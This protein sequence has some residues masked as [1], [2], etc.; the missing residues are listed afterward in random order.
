[1]SLFDGSA[2]F[3]Q[4][5]ILDT[6]TMTRSSN[7]ELPDGD[8]VIAH[9]KWFNIPKGF[10]FVVP[11]GTAIDAFLHITT[12]QRAGIKAIGE[13][14]VLICT[15]EKGPKGAQVRE[16][17]EILN[18]GMKPERVKQA[19]H[20]MAVRNGAENG[21]AEDIAPESPSL[22]L[23]GAVK[24]YKPDKGFGF[25]T[26]DDGQKDIFLHKSCLEKYG[27]D[28]LQ[29]GLRLS[30]QVRIVPKGREVL[31]FEIIEG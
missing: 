14:A 28:D 1:M 25:V 15:L 2:F 16:V 12:L 26:P 18:A 4:E 31:D 9:L 11:E 13:G 5:K 27:L 3:M 21:L 6:E 23:E 17:L 8:S 30:M 22:R 24:W 20:L 29:P 7:L 19:P 10:G